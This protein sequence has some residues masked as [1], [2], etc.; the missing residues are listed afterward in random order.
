MTTDTHA[1]ALIEAAQEFHDEGF[2]IAYVPIVGYE[3]QSNGKTKH[4]TGK[5]PI[6]PGWQDGLSIEVVKDGILRLNSHAGGIGIVAGRQPNG[7]DL[8]MLDFDGD[9][10]SQGYNAT[11]AM[12]PELE[13]TRTT[14]TGSGKRQIWVYL[15]SMP[16][17]YTNED[18][19]RDAKAHTELRCNRS[20]CMCPPSLHPSSNLYDWAPWRDADEIVTLDYQTLRVWLVDWAGMDPKKANKDSG[21]RF[22]LPDK[23]HDGERNKTLFS[24]ACKLRA[25]QEGMDFDEILGA[26]TFI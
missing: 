12:F 10:W 17:G 6:A 20:F 19:V 26:V 13:E 2:K 16:A 4:A 9:D 24:Y 22:K 14:K 8:G 1:Q 18:F 7:H 15:E 3:Y 5:G 25:H 11:L 21:D 23:I